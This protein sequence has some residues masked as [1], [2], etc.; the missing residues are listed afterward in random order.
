[1]KQT[2]ILV[3]LC[4]TLHSESGLAAV[5]ATTANGESTNTTSSSSSSQLDDVCEILYPT[6][7]QCL[8]D[9]RC[10]W[11]G[12]ENWT[13]PDGKCYELKNAVNCCYGTGSGNPIF[14]VPEALLCR[15]ENSNC[16]RTT[17]E[18]T[19]GPCGIAQC[20]NA[21]E[22]VLCPYSGCHPS[23][24]TCCGDHSCAPESFCCGWSSPIGGYPCCDSATQQCCT[25]PDGY[26][27]WCCGLD[28]AC[29]YNS[30]L[31][32]SPPSPAP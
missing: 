3:A 8:S 17:M 12:H 14:C 9:Q 13:Y 27:G 15:G 10:G 21:T 26:E 31:C 22:N 18:T 6:Y 28:E 30:G 7:E 5:E 20:C 24:W 2:L 1:M 25:S 29:D 32:V 16:V 4:L 19:Y 23:N 11:C